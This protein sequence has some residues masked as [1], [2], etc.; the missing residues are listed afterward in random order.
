[1]QPERGELTLVGELLR[2]ALASS[3]HAIEAAR[4]ALAMVR[5]GCRRAAAQGAS[6]DEIAV[7][8]GV[9]REFAEALTAQDTVGPI[10]LLDPV[11]AAQLRF[12][13]EIQQNP[14]WTMGGLVGCTTGASGLTLLWHQPDVG[15]RQLVDSEARQLGVAIAHD[16][17]PA[18]SADMD[19][20]MAPLV[21]QVGLTAI[22]D[23]RLSP[24]GASVRVAS[25]G[26]PHLRDLHT[27]L[28]S[29]VDL[30][31]GLDDQFQGVSG[32]RR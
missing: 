24:R 11:A 16:D 1:M 18:S 20:V 5:R 3:E 4:S 13:M 31:G 21:A 25:T 28:P 27:Q 29:W 7:S 6:V 17:F 14:A 19:L 26:A 23:A 2:T 30:R 32:R 15:A 8:L 12:V 9:S 22:R 10:E